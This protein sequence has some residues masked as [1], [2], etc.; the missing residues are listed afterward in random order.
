VDVSKYFDTI[1]HEKL[2]RLVSPLCDQATKELIG[3]LLSVGYVDI[4]NLSN[5][6]LRND[7]GT[8]QGSL[9]SP[10]LANLYLHELDRFVDTNLIPK[11]N[12]GDERR[13]VEGY[14]T[15]KVLTSG[16]KQ[17]LDQL[18][19]EGIHEVVQAYKHTKWV[20]DGGTS[21]DPKDPNFNR[22]HYVRYAD[23][24]LF[25][26]TGTRD[27]AKSIMNEVTEFLDRELKLKV[28]ENK[29]GIHHSSD[30]NIKFLGF[31]IK[32]LPPKRTLDKIKL[33]AGIKQT[34]MVAIN[35]AQLRIPVEQIFNR[36]VDKGYA[37][38]RKDGTI[39]ATSFRKISDLEDKL[40]VNRFSSV[41]R[42]YLNYYQP[43]NQYSDM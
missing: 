14:Q 18:G 10:M 5:S 39:R 42:G 40:I 26:F 43:A 33:E 36:L 7:L 31:F 6:V 29:S 34:K 35:Q 41:I 38:R 4:S 2:L 23:D 20:N 1:H 30:K 22:L 16:Q 32:Y 27:D 3:K 15:R 13:F 9:I 28:N 17:L 37:T 25:G 8:P 11:W 12:R 24:F 21:R 19:I